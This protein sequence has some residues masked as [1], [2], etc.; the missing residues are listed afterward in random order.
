SEFNTPSSPDNWRLLRR[1]DA[2]EVN[3]LFTINPTTVLSLRY[4]FNRFPNFSYDGSQGYNIGN[5]GFPASLVSAIP[6]AISQFPP[7]NMTSL[8]S[9]EQ[10]A[11]DNNG[12][13]DLDSK[14]FSTSVSKYM[15][16]HS[17]KAG[18]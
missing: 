5:L 18:F 4:G 15:G 6:P 16:R 7:V 3:S 17:L 14:N 11:G 13:T 9:L 12:Y 1:V 2:T 10:G 8:Y